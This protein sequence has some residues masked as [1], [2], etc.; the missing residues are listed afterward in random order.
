MPSIYL[1]S[2]ILVMDARLER[3]KAIAGSG[4]VRQAPDGTWLVLS[5]TLPK[6]RYKVNPA[7]K[8]P[9]CSCPDFQNWELPCKHIYAVRISLDPSQPEPQEKETN[10][11]EHVMPRPTYTQD[12]AAYN[13][14]QIHE[15]EHFEIL[16]H[17]LCSGI[18]QPKQEAGRPRLPL[19]DVV[20]ACVTK[21][22]TEKSGR[23]ASTDVRACREKGHITRPPHHNS[24]SRYLLTPEL[25]PVLTKLIEQT[26]APLKAVESQFAVDATGFSTCTYTRWFDHKYG[27]EAKKQRWIKCHAMVGTRT[28]VVTSVEITESNV[29]DTTMLPDLIASTSKTF[30]LK[31]VSADKAYLGTQNLLTIEAFGAE[32]F[33]P[34]KIDS[35]QGRTS[36]WQRM[37]HMFWFKRDEFLHHYH[38]R[39]NVEST[40]SMIK[41]K[42][43]GAVRSKKLE[44][45][46][47]E[48]LCKV[49]AHNIV[50]L[51]HEMYELGI[52]PQLG[53]GSTQQHELH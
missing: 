30:N 1:I 53:H 17:D 26:A 5:Q 39:S 52:D 43:G 12:W 47:N 48:V 38:R 51:I 32:P 19:A 46:I 24:I 42:F 2:N 7:A 3:G 14:A 27:Q 8:A 25:K 4:K 16:L 22:Y 35:K 41:R 18:E 23:R 15:R 29:A 11:Q 40:F 37:W 20:Y 9:S 34:F 36:A 31:E 10:E 49:L 45:Q 6:T 50:V 21:V 13:K 28:N 44:S 33:I